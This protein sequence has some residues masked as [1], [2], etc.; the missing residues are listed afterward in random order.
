VVETSW[1]EWFR[2]IYPV[3]VTLVSLAGLGCVL[4]LGTKFASKVTVEKH[5]QS[6]S[7]HETRIELLEAHN[8]ASPTRAELHDELT[9]L[10]S[11]MSGMESALKGVGKQIDTTNTYLHTVIEKALGGSKP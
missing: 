7:D 11:R 8:E 2:A 10:A 3:F 4:W 5:G 9:N 6:L 1:L